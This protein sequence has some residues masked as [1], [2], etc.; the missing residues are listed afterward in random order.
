MS[1]AVIGAVVAVVAGAAVANQQKVAAKQD[2]AKAAKK[3]AAVATQEAGE[4]QDIN[5]QQMAIQAMTSQTQQLD[6]VLAAQSNPPNI[7]TLPSA[8]STDPLERINRAIDDFLKGK[9]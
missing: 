3:A 8:E 7:L 1:V 4:Y 5:R 2:V 6:Q 9:R